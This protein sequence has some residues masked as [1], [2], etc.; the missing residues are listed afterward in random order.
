[1]SFSLSQARRF[2]EQGAV[3]RAHLYGAPSTGIDPAEPNLQLGTVQFRA[4]LFKLST[5]V[6]AVVH[7]KTINCT[8]KVLIPKSLNLV[9]DESSLFTEIATGEVFEVVQIGVENSTLAE[10]PVLLR[11][12]EP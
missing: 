9:F 3:Q 1:M 4:A 7:G 5:V 2:A 10:T 12:Q 6:Q 11:R 8:A